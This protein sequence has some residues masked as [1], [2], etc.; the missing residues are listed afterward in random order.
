MHV[1]V[2]KIDGKN[3]QLP[4]DTKLLPDILVYVLRFTFTTADQVEVQNQSESGSCFSPIIWMQ[5]VRFCGGLRSSE[6]R[7]SLK[8]ERLG[9]KSWPEHHFVF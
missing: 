4:G 8:V 1:H 2:Q 5:I 9:L 7:A 3:M 6:Q